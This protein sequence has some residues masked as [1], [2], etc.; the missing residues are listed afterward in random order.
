MQFGRRL[1]D[2]NDLRTGLESDVQLI[3]VTCQKSRPDV[4]KL[5][6]HAPTAQAEG[7]HDLKRN[8]SEAV[9]EVRLTGAAAEGQ[10]GATR[11]FTRL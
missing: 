9:G 2:Q 6:Q 8:L 4:E 1:I 7:A 10:L 5:H 11:S 3:T